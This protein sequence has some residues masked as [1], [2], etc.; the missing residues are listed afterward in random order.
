MS[1]IHITLPTRDLARTVRFFEDAFGWRP[2]DR[3]DNVAVPGAFLAIAPGQEIHFI[4]I[5]SFEPSPFEREY[6]R[7]VA[8]SAPREQFHQLKERLQRLGAELI[9]PVRATPFDRFFFR[10]LNGY[11]FEVVEEAATA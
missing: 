1:I 8:L 9:D 7:H 6:G 4:E 2:I 5:S 3:P 11:I 10:D